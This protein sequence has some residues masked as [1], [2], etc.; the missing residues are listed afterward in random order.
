VIYATPVQQDPLAI[1]TMLPFA[2]L[3]LAMAVLP[4][5]L[6]K[7]WQRHW[8]QLLVVLACAAP[9]VTYLLIHGRAPDVWHSASQYVTFIV[10]LAALFVA[11][12]GVYAV[13]DFEATPWTNVRFLLVGSLLAS[14]IGT[15]GASMLLLRPLL[16]TNSQRQHRAHIVPFFIVAVANAGGLLTPLGDPP[17]LVGFIAGVPFF[18]TLRLWPVWALYVGSAALGLYLADRRAYARE[19]PEDIARDRTEVKPLSVRGFRNV[20]WLLLVI[21]AIFLP[22]VLRELG[23]LGIAAASYFG[24]PRE[25]HRLNGFSLL[26]ILEVGL[27]F[28]GLFACLV[29]I[30][31]GLA[32]LAPGLP[33]Q[34]SWQLFWASGVLSAVLDN[35]PTYAAFAALA[36]GLGGQHSDLVAGIRPLALAAISAGTVV[37]GA[38]TYIGNGP[39]L[40]IKA[41]AERSGY[42]L[43]SFFRYALFALIVLSAGHVV[44]TLAFVLLEAG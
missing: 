10:T 40:M 11:A 24:T 35:A 38:T 26:P 5:L 28:F 43:P 37:M 18:W 6:P 4:V 8:F 21:G 32:A 9:V 27:L 23:L 3:V 44:M 34:K 17:L 30:E 20:G 14:L 15:T 36:R 41:I 22:P 25:I 7:L 29:P 39:N 19:A 2:V 12:G 1:W 31:I 16:R 13:G 33:L 42:V